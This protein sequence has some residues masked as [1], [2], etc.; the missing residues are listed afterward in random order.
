M[1]R[2]FT[3]SRRQEKDREGKGEKESG[4]RTRI[5]GAASEEQLRDLLSQRET[6]DGLTASFR[7][8]LIDRNARLLIK[9]STNY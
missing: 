9:H 8:N 7:R 6:R 2:D 3:I 1:S 5:L 4:Q